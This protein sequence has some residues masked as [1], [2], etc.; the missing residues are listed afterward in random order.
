MARAAVPAQALA[1]AFAALDG[2]AT[3]A[4]AAAAGGIGERTLKRYKS[5]RAT[6]ASPS[7]APKAPPATPAAGVI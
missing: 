5:S 3:D 6:S 7:R 1:R 4:E 2:G